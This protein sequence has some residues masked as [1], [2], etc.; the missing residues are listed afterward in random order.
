MLISGR[1]FSSV[2]TMIF[3]AGLTPAWQQIAV[4]D[5]LQ[6]GEVNRAREVH[7]CASGKVLNVGLA[8]THLKSQVLVASRTLSLI[9]SGPANVA[10]RHDMQQRGVDV[11]WVD[12][13]APQRVCTTLLDRQSGST[14]EIVENFPPATQQEL[15]AFVTAFAEE[16]AQP[17]V[18]FVVLTGSLPQGAPPD[19]YL[20][21]LEQT[22]AKTILD[23]RGPELLAALARKPFLVKPNREELGHTVGRVLVDDADVWQ[24][25]AEL[26][27]LGAE[28]VVVTNGPGEVFA[29]HDDE[30]LRFMPPTVEVVNPIGC[31]DCFTA[32]LAWSLHQGH[33]MRQAIQIGIAA[34]A[35]N[36]TQLLPARLVGPFEID[37]SCASRNSAGTR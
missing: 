32:G 23:F 16:A 22:D 2:V 5:R 4:L 21:L 13:T 7:W 33:A 29:T 35:E 15:D 9:G 10:M 6:T 14:T 8:L 11:R 3:V 31:G 28:W 36:A 34:S 37:A 1:L 26:N 30:R 25:M 20:T 17:E 19:F 27:S 18:Q 12:A 24:A